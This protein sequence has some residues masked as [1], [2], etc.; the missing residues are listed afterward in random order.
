M[1]R[2]TKK[3]SPVVNDLRKDLTNLLVNLSLID[4]DILLASLSSSVISG[5]SSKGGL[6]NYLSVNSGADHSSNFQT[7]S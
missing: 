7:V 3:N 4:G 5:S 6:E 1:S 2:Q